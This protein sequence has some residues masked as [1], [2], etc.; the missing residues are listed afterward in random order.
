MKKYLMTILM[1]AAFAVLCSSTVMAKERKI[2]YKVKNGT[3]VITGKSGMPDHVDFGKKKSTKNIKKLIIKKGVTSVSD[4]A[5]K[6]CKKLKSVKLA[7]TIYKIGYNAFEGTALKRITIPKSVKYIGIFSFNNCKNLEEVTAP[8][9]FSLLGSDESNINNNVLKK[10]IFNTPIKS[11]Y[12]LACTQFNTIDYVVDKNDKNYSSHNGDIYSKDGKKLEFVSRHKIDFKIYNKCETI[13]TY[14]F[15]H[16]LG[17]D[18][19]V[20]CD[21][22]KKITIPSTVKHVLYEC[23]DAFFSNTVFDV[24]TSGMGTDDICRLCMFIGLRNT[25]KYLSKDVKRE[26]NVLHV[27]EK[28][29]YIDDDY[30]DI[31]FTEPQKYDNPVTVETGSAEVDPFSNPTEVDVTRTENSSYYKFSKKMAGKRIT[32][33]VKEDGLFILKTNGNI[34]LYNGKSE[35]VSLY[36]IVKAGE[37]FYLQLPE[38]MTKKYSV[39]YAYVENLNWKS[40]DT[41]DVDEIYKVGN[42]GYQYFDF[43]MKKTRDY[44]VR[45]TDY[46]NAGLANISFV[47]QK[48]VG[49]KWKDCT[50]RRKLVTGKDWMQYSGLST[51]SFARHFLT[52]LEKGKYRLKIKAK[53]GAIYTVYGSWIENSGKAPVKMVSNRKKAP[54]LF[55]REAGIDEDGVSDF[56]RKGHFTQTNA[57]THWY[58]FTKDI[59]ANGRIQV[60]I[61]GASTGKYEVSLYKKGS[62]KKL[63]TKYIDPRKILKNPK[64]SGDNGVINFK[65]KKR[66]VYY[67]KIHRFNKKSTASYVCSFQYLQARV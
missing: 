51:G 58:K 19:Y 5:F 38:T 28:K 37:K 21:K 27:R 52:N 61:N 7:K 42:G 66:G 6:N 22:I 60:E 3:M 30:D 1:F 40:L 63:R 35:L 44:D 29:L 45:I 2:N 14:A 50:T 33:N 24:D 57:K 26:G 67:V 43:S 18:C 31:Y 32:F 47:I 16:D 48:K 46:K 41:E 36:P 10:V 62:S 34:K 13:Y 56:Y 4:D 11:H 25:E 15:N 55:E 49:K 8:G 23:H 39:K 9:D 53:K 12:N 17:D 65:V 59:K 54:E 64:K 20:T